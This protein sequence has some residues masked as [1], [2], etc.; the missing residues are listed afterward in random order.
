ME[1]HEYFTKMTRMANE[2]AA[3]DPNLQAALRKYAGR[4]LVLRVRN[5]ATYVFR[6]SAEGV[7][8]EANPSSLPNDMYAEMNMAQAKR[9]V[10]QQTLGLMDLFSIKHRNI[11]LDD[12][13]F[14]KRLFRS[15]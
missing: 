1:F 7:E 13:N 9:L 2:K 10:Y 4:S 8:Y 15:F 11:S 6:F 12:V 5:D 14:A 3:T